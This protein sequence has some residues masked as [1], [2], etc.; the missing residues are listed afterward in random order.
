LEDILDKIQVRWGRDTGKQL[1][2]EHEPRVRKKKV[3][4]RAYWHANIR[5]RGFRRAEFAVS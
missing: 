3:E 4:R 2:G 1:R 5:S